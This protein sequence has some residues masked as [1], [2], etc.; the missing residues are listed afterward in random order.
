MEKRLAAREPVFHIPQSPSAAAGIDVIP[1]L[2]AQADAVAARHHD[3]GWP[4]INIKLIDLTG[5]RRVRISTAPM[6]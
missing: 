4:D 3:A 6:S 2:N 5:D 1:A